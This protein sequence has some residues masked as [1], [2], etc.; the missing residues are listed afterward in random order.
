MRVILILL[1]ITLFSTT[2]LSKE[3]IRHNH[4][5]KHFEIIR[6]I[7]IAALDE[8]KSEY[9]DYVLKEAEFIPQGREVELVRDNEFF[10]V[11]WS[12]SSPERESKVQSIPI[13]LL[14]GLIGLRVMIIKKNNQD[15]FPI[16]LN[17][18]DFKNIRLGQANDW[19]D[20]D[21]LEFN[22]MSLFRFPNYKT[23]FQL[24]NNSRFLGYPRGITEALSEIEENKNFEFVLEKNHLLYYPAPFYFYV[25]KKN[26]KLYN[27]L[28]LGLN[29]LIEKGEFD[30]LLFSDPT[31]RDALINTNIT[32]RKVH[33]LANPLFDDQKVLD[34][35]RLWIDMTKIDEYLKKYK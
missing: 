31:V 10:Q 21:I 35:K 8:T 6:K 25:S 12:M 26:K 24:L 33:Y 34:D 23:S 28:L 4:V 5:Y 32:D 22:G 16:S 15:K 27:R 2:T 17:I 20:S 19:P 14:K 9:G 29:R 11:M 30:K 7:L 18:E 3:I 13:P 1:F